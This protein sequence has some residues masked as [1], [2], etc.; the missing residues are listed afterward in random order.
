MTTTRRR[1]LAAAL[2]A[3]AVG[4]AKP[5]LLLAKDPPVVWVK[6]AK[7]PMLSLGTG[8][9]FDS[10][11]IMS[12]AIARDGK[13]CFLFYAGGP[14]GPLT[15]EDLVRYQLGLAVSDD[16]EKWTKRAK[17]L[18]PL[19]ERD[20]FHCTPALLRNPDGNLVK[21]EGLWHLLYCGNRA[22]DVEHATS[23]D[24][25]TWEK[26]P[27]NPIYKRAYA[28]N[29]LQ[30]GDENWMYYVHKPAKKDGKEIPWEIH[31]AT[32]RDFYSLKAHR[33]NPVLKLSQT[34]ENAH[35]FYP[36]VLKEGKTW[37]MFYASYWK[38]H[39]QS[40][41]IGMA[42][43]ADGL[44]WT[45]SD[46]NPVLVPT[47]GSTFDSKYTSAQCVL[48][49]GDHY[50]MYYGARINQIHK[51]YAIGLATYRGMLAPQQR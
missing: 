26:D 13:Q 15:K 21:K 29:L 6:S 24:G 36:Y 1:F 42:T 41:A 34:W 30:V 25:L 7:N 46:A 38:G 10:Q 39:P 33:A 49:D 20:N 8:D 2:G 19:G 50:K 12:P 32:G 40:T 51:Y 48:R 17:P 27:R 11:N 37:L 9:A 31:L 23:R 44:W 14:A 35:L 5:R 16:G 28:P 18:L 47:P 43:S 3:T 22:D 45:K 4:L